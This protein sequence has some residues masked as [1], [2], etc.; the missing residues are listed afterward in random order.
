MIS[1]NALDK[2]VPEGWQKELLKAGFA[3]THDK[4]VVIDPFADDCVVVTGS[5]NLGYGRTS[6]SGLCNSRPRRLD[7]GSD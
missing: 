3:I 7:S 1:A 6:Y 5:H 2:T 4:I